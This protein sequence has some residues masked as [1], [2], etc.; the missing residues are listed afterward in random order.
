MLQLPEIITNF[1]FINETKTRNMNKTIKS[2]LKYLQIKAFNPYLKYMNFLSR[3]GGGKQHQEALPHKLLIITVAYNTPVLI[4]KQIELIKKYVEDE[5]YQL[6]VADNSTQKK[7]RNIIR[8]I[9][10]EAHTEYIP[11]PMFINKLHL[12]KIFYGGASHGAALNW[13]FYHVITP[14]EPQYF[15]FL[16]HDV[17]PF[18]SSNLQKHIE[19]KDFYGIDRNK[20]NGW[21][22]WPGYCIF[23]F[24]S[25][26]KAHPNF[27]PMY[28]GKEYFDTG[29]SNYIQIYKQH[30]RMGTYFAKCETSRFKE[31]EGLMRHD[32]IYHADC[33]QFIDDTWVHLINGSNCA[34]IK[35]KEKTVEKLLKNIY[36]IQELA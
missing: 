18:A 23:N 1:A 4:K 25:I 14:R 11:I 10:E 3:L 26:Q 7:Y 29:G 20:K 27:L 2:I 19:G 12:H 15:A 16:D 32:Q 17:L 13:M 21:Y 30:P 36:R 34:H 8:Q 31:T 28:I 5:D 22:I 24:K 6:I 35:G 9:C 33:I